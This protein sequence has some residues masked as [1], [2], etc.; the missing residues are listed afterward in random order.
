[1]RIL[2]FTGASNSSGGA[3]QAAYLA[4][5]LERRGHEVIFLVPPDSSLP[6]RGFE[7]SW[8]KAPSGKW[9]AV[10]TEYMEKKAPGIIQ[11]FHNKAV[12]FLAGRAFLWRL[13][14]RGFVCFGYRGVI[15]P[16][17][18]PLPYL[19]PGMDGFICNSQAAARAIRRVSL[20]LART[21]VVPNA[22]PG[23]RLLPERE[24]ETIRD[25]LSLEP[26]S[27]V[28]GAIGGNARVKGI[29]V[30]LHAFA[31]ARRSGAL[32]DTAVLLVVG[33][34]PR[35]W[36]PLCHELGILRQTRL[37]GHANTVADYLQCMDMFVIPS[38]S[39]SF[40]N[41]LLEAMGMGLPVIASAVG[42]IPEIMEPDSEKA[43]GATEALGK[44]AGGILV[45]P[46]DPAAL[47]SALGYL[48]A[49]APVRVRM[50]ERNRLR[51]EEFSLAK[52]AE[53]FEA[54]YE[55]ALRLSGRLDKS[56]ASSKMR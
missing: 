17:R 24:R 12:K 30:L 21:F 23:E 33:V 38:L 45:P 47:A 15:Y 5:E 20:G 14:K 13:R 46:G 2:F 51:R 48:A 49:D 37:L 6:G 41:T 55:E 18:N 7:V 9:G 28:V 39:E 22:I 43:V 52:R 26:G 54:I 31:L 3:R 36:Q 34:D 53:R 44:T 56:G 10:I 19:S 29:A 40:P 1:M 8:Q 35:L 4:Q 50:G 11:A 32:A 27:L 25:E 16:P 42:G